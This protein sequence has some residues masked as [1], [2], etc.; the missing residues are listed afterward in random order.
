MIWISNDVPG[1]YSSSAGDF[2][3]AHNRTGH[4]LG[5]GVQTRTD[6]PA[7]QTPDRYN[8]ETTELPGKRVARAALRWGRAPAKPELA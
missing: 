4:F 1:G 2:A 6:Q 8:L 7:G 5:L 3:S